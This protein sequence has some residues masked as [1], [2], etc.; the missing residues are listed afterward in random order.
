MAA[1]SLNH[2]DVSRSLDKHSA[3]LNKM[4]SGEADRA[5]QS[6]LNR[7]ITK[8]R[9]SALK[10]T[11]NELGVP[12]KVVKG[13]FAKPKR[14]RPKDLSVRQNAYSRSIN[15]VALGAKKVDSGLSKGPYHWDQAFI[16]TSPYSG[17]DVAIQRKG[18]KRYPTKAAEL[19]KRFV[20]RVTKK[21]LNT[22]GD[23][24]VRSELSRDLKQEYEKRFNRLV[25]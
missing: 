3:A 15:A 4:K 17:R 20:G 13:R 16:V 7:G 9:K 1:V 11:S 8:I 12:Q 22:A 6:V 25:R 18:K 24:F 23:K 5:L 21:A 19:D 2:R 10:Q 14:A